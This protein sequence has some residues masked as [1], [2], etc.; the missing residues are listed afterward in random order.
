MTYITSTTLYT[1][2]VSLKRT[3]FELLK[4]PRHFKI[5]ISGSGRARWKMQ[6]PGEVGRV[7]TLVITNTWKAVNGRDWCKEKEENDKKDIK[8]KNGRIRAHSHYYNYTDYDNRK[9]N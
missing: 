2:L 3:V 7:S 9:F 4:I 5:S 8:R 1:L 6:Q